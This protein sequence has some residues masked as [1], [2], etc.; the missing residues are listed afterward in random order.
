[1]KNLTISRIEPTNPV[2]LSYIDKVNEWDKEGTIQLRK[3][4]HIIPFYALYYDATFLAAGT[5]E[6]DKVNS[7]AKVAMVN[8]S[9]FY[10]DDIQ[11]AAISKFERLV[12]NE[13]G[14]NDIEFSYAKKRG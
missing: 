5:I 1:M 11:A 14:T 7:K 2:V 13:Y 8:G 10:Y 6:F 4:N 9:H 3:D 12:E